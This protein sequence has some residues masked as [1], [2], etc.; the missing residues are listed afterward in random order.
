MSK[1]LGLTLV[2]ALGSAGCPAAAPED[3][4][5]DALGR[6]AFLDDAASSDASGLD[7]S[8][9]DA[10]PD[11]PGADAGGPSRSLRFFGHGREAVDRVVIPL[12]TPPRPADVGAGDFTLE[13]FVRMRAGDN[14]SGDCR[15][16]NDGWIYGHVV[17]D[18]DVYG[19]GDRGDYGLSIFDG[20]VAFGL[21]SADVGL[22]LCGRSRLDDERWHHIAVTR[23]LA[24]RRVVLYVDGLPEAEGIGPSGD[25]SYRDGRESPY[26]YDP[27][28]VLGAEKHDAGEAY[29]SYAGWID[30]LRLS[31][32][33]R[34]SGDFTPP[35]APFEA[36]ADTAAL[37]HFDEAAGLEV[38]D[39][40]GGGS[41][42][43]LRV[44]GEPLGPVWSM[45]SPF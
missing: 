14:P 41:V 39:A 36:D 27:T 40:S 2:L 33:V 6:D 12:D 29:P 15:A 17:V 25:L 37:Y 35:V 34:Y 28:L 31:S 43:A 10:T 3:A 32:R 18:R 42:G 9:D 38:G 8:I 11:A 7:G 5:A 24:S 4:G 23:E 30:E 45:E 21:A 16:E 13:L 1:R 26:P 22:G 19:G 20:V 44:G